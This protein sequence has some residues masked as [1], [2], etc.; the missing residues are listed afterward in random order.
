MHLGTKTPLRIAAASLSLA[1]AGLLGGCAANFTPS[2]LQSDQ[3][4]LGNIQGTVHG[5][6]SPISGAEI[7]LFA[8][9]TSGYG[10][11]ATS[12]IK[13]TG[14]G[15]AQETIS[16]FAGDYYV[17]TD[18]NGNFSLNG[19]YT[20]TAGQQVYMVAYSGNPGNGNG[21]GSDNTT[22]MQ[23][24][25]LGQCPASGTMAA[26]VPYLVVN[27]ISTVAFAYAMSAYGS[28]A[29]NIG[30]PNTTEGQA[31]IANA[32]N[33]VFNIVNIAYGQSPTT[34]NFNA[35]GI[36]PQS[37]IYTLANIL[38][39]CVNT[40]GPG[41]GQGSGNKNA[42]NY[43]FQYTNNTTDE[44][45][46]IFYIA[47]NPTS[48]VS[49][50][51]GLQPAAPVFSPSLS[52]APTDWTVPIVY[53]NAVSTFTIA[54]NTTVSGPFNIAFDANGNAWIGDRARGVV[55][56]SPQG[57]VST[58]NLNFGM[59][60]GVSVSP[61]GNIWAVDYSNNAMYIMDT[62]GHLNTTITSGLNGPD[63]VAFDSSGNAYVTNETG[64]S[65]SVYNPSGTLLH[66]PTAFS[67][68]STPGFIAVDT[69][70]NA[71]IPS[72]SSS[73]VGE[74]T[75]QTNANNISAGGGSY[76]VI[77]DASNNP[78]LGDFSNSRLDEI[79][80]STF[81]GITFYNTA[82]HTGGGL[83]GPYHLAFDGSGNIW[84]GNEGAS[85]V[86]GWSTSSSAWL[87]SSGFTT[88]TTGQNVAAVPD[89]SG[90]LWVA[91][92]DGS[93]TQILGLATPTYAPLLPGKVATKP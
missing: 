24:A 9:G 44:A 42:C 38:G 61:S 70:G 85:V 83:N 23:M 11:A 74:L 57:A 58:F 2:A 28:S 84:V 43:L 52:T 79:T 16:P 21:V 90:N 5:G 47:H 76:A 86:S 7:F 91:N 73:N 19:D 66:G 63:A 81:L 1:A 51:Y 54:N 17:T 71:W 56:M 27:E 22:I 10:S 36:V 33:N 67:S 75:G 77:L 25:A 46:A 49:N 18:A 65:V 31:G 87:A 60:K 37:K 50:L 34:A 39:A 69:S 88:G 41:K 3:A 35:N 13:S 68:V 40:K 72:T 8:A 89:I 32:M 55:K 26:Q 4:S 29:T 78:W 59:I 80:T 53:Q 15:V 82:T 62:T 30:A 14:T 93:I 20:C 12:L 48:N 45:S 92:T 64:N 6:Q